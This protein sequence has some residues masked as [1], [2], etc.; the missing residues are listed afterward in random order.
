MNSV[1]NKLIQI[2]V[3]EFITAVIFLLMLSICSEIDKISTILK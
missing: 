2:I 3:S 1:D